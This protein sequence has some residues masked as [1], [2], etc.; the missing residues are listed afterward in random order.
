MP[1][2]RRRSDPDRVPSGRRL[3]DKVVDLVGLLA[4]LLGA[5][6]VYR[7]TGPGAFT[8]VLGGVTALYALLQGGRGNRRR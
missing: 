1:T 8:G 4:L 2:P 6:V 5:A 3:A 7:V